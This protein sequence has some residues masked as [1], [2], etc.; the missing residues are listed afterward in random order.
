MRLTRKGFLAGLGS[1]GGLPG[2]RTAETPSA[3][4]GDTLDAWQGETG[5]LD[6][7]GYDQQVARRGCCCSSAKKSVIKQCRH[8]QKNVCTAA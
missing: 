4:E 2:C 8:C 3:R 1:V 6:L 7:N 5:G